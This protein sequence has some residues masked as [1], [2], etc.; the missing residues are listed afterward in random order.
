MHKNVFF[1]G[2]SNVNF[3]S[4]YFNG[5]MSVKMKLNSGAVVHR[6]WG[7]WEALYGMLQQQ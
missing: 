4:I 7:M 2:V 5:F 1:K 3:K 6:C